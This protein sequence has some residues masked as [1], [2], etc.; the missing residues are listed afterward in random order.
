MQ[1][2]RYRQGDRPKRDHRE[3]DREGPVAL[4]EAIEDAGLKNRREEAVQ[5]GDNGGPDEDPGLLFVRD[6]EL[7]DAEQGFAAVDT[8]GARA[9]FVGQQAVALGAP[10]PLLFQVDGER[11]A[12]GK[13]LDPPGRLAKLVRQC[14][15]VR[16][17]DNVLSRLGADEQPASTDERVVFGV[18]NLADRDA[19]GRCAGLVLDPDFAFSHDQAADSVLGGF[20]QVGLK[21]NEDPIDLARKVGLL[22]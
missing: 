19:E 11:F 12:F 2:R 16:G 15:A 22:N 5:G 21:I 18:G 13:L 8:V 14:Q 3:Q 20:R 4:G 6:D 9:V 1:G 10:C 7:R 17:G